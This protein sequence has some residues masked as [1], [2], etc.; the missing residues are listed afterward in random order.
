ML[1][2]RIGP[3]YPSWIAFGWFIAA[4][5]TSLLI[6]GLFALGV[7]AAEEGRAE[8][9]WTTL[10]LVVGF[11]AGGFYTGAR[12]GPYAWAHGIGIG[13]FSFVV[14]IG[15]NLVLGEPTGET[16]W[17]GLTAGSAVSL[18]VVQALAAVGGCWLGDRIAHTP[19]E[20]ETA[21]G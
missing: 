10:A 21:A 1:S 7:L 12:V 16:T 5:I 3:I 4:S 8:I 11:G 17:G 2:T 14:W 9:L 19:P 18:L 15:L 13:L 20:A 6:L